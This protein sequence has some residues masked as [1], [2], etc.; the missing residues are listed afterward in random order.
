MKLIRVGVDLLKRVF[1]VHS[2]D[3]HEQVV[4]RRKLSGGVL[5]KTLLKSSPNPIASSECAKRG[6]LKACAA[7]PTGDGSKSQPS[8]S[9]ASYRS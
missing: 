1:Q 6:A 2:V 5:L 3:R 7:L 4:C 8:L 9:L